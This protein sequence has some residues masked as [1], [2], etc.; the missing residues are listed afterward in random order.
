MGWR[1][2]TCA[3]SVDGT[4]QGAQC[5]FYTTAYNAHLIDILR[6]VHMRLQ[7]IE[8]SA[9]RHF[10]HLE[11]GHRIQGLHTVPRKY[12]I[13]F[14]GNVLTWSISSKWRA[15]FCVISAA[16]RG[17]QCMASM[18][19]GGTAKYLCIMLLLSLMT[20]YKGTHT[21]HSTFQCWLG[22]QHVRFGQ[23]A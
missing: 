23:V 15:V 8:V 1:C 2:S 11:K 9:L 7:Q 10:V 18:P 17:K 14:Y 13:D 5:N 16:S 22:L 12:K 20:I 19:N 6:Q 3:H 21:I 4:R